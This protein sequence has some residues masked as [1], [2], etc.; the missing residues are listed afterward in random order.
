V[1][2]NRT[3]EQAI[4]PYPASVRRVASDARALILNSLS[5]IQERVDGSRALIGYGYAA[6]YTGLVCTLILS[7][8]GV[9]LGIIDGATLADPEGI[10]EGD[11]NRHRHI[12]LK[13]S[14]DV[15][16]PP[17]REYLRA[18]HHAWQKRHGE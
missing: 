3:F 9:K 7:Q 16:R 1:K 4:A 14:S 8:R 5:A 2:G 18:A 17:V 13:A 15:S 10:L 6:G 12:A 11:G